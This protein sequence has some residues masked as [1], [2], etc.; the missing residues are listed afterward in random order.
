MSGGGPPRRGRSPPCDQ[1]HGDITRPPSTECSSNR[2][3]PVLDDY[4]SALFSSDPNERAYAL[5]R[6]SEQT[7]DDVRLPA[8]LP[9]GRILLAQ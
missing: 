5:P 7:N 6:A 4:L 1:R 3:V 9:V 8:S 2:P